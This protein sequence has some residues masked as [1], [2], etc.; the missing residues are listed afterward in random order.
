MSADTPKPNNPK[1]EQ[2]GASDESIQ[3]VHAILL[4]EKA[5]PAEGYT[6]MPLFILGFIS[7]AIFIVSIYFVH[8]RAGFDPLAYDERFDP[9]KMTK[10]GGAGAAVDPLVAGKKLFN[11]CATCHQLTGQG[12]AGVYPPLAGSEWVTG[13]EDRLI[14]ILLHGLGGS[15]TVKGNTYNGAMPAFGNVPE[16]GY[17]WS[18]DKIAQVL[19]YI[20]HE[21]GNNASPIT[22]EKVKEV[23]TQS[24]TGRNKPWT[25]A[26]LLAVP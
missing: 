12:V 16:S 4:R 20:R 15:V 26:E 7:A 10:A 18:D 9:A 1:V 3:Q 17:K 2:A 25:E 22:A 13:S 21:W 23:R 24:A 6:P 11:T 19:T 14:R 5:E 8:H